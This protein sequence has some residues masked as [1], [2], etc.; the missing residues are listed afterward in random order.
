[1]VSAQPPWRLPSPE[2]SRYHDSA[3]FDVHLLCYPW[4]VSESRADA[5]LDRVRGEIGATGLTVVA[6]TRPVCQ[7]R[8]CPGA[9][10]RI[11]RSSGGLLFQP[12]KTRYDSTRCKPVTADWLKSRHPLQHLADACRKRDLPLRALIDTRRIGRMAERNPLFAMK[13][14]TGDPSPG[15][16]CLTNSDVVE[17]F[18]AAIADLRSNYGVSRVELCDLDQPFRTDLLDGSESGHCLGTAGRE[19]LAV[20]FCESCVQAARRNNVDV[21]AARHS[22]HQRLT[23][24]IESGRRLEGSLADLLADDSALS[25]YVDDRRAAHDEVVQLLCKQAPADIALHVPGHAESTAYLPSVAAGCSTVILDFD[26][27]PSRLHDSFQLPSG[28]KLEARIPVHGPAATDP[29]TLVMT[30]PRLVDAGL[31]GVTLDHFGAMSDAEM[32]A[33]RQAVRFARRSAAD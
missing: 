5:V 11:F 32:T 18:V 22:A 16:L 20:C 2:R 12:D 9:S 1:M 3:M 30:L 26:E 7:L 4:D 27:I 13:S 6:A 21:D 24:A 14:A 23:T 10:P 33:A 15:C 19:L 29:A 31:A 17:F 28:V 8:R 25:A